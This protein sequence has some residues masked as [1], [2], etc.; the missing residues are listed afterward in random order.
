[1]DSIIQILALLNGLPVITRVIAIELG[2]IPFHTE[3][4]LHGQQHGPNQ[5]HIVRLMKE[6][7]QNSLLDDIIILQNEQRTKSAARLI[8]AYCKKG[9]KR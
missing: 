8:N 3:N 4:G 9:T 6:L 1:M 5:K 2:L 7:L